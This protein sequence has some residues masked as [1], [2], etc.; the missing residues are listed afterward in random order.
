MT[1]LTCVHW[2]LGE[3]RVFT[4]AFHCTLFDTNFFVSCQ[5]AS[6]LSHHFLYH[7][8][9]SLSAFQLFLCPWDSIQ[10][11]VCW[12]L[13]HLSFIRAHS[14]ILP[15]PYFLPYSCLSWSSPKFIIAD[16]F[17]PEYSKNVCRHLFKNIC[18]LLGLEL[19][20]VLHPYKSTDFT[21]VSNFFLLICWHL[22]ECLSCAKALKL[23]NY[24]VLNKIS[25]ILSLSS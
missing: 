3:V 14:F 23:I 25:F 22:H 20:Q 13:S 11:L 17:W 24:M 15:F 9:P 7:P 10:E 4:K 21:M 16:S 18:D 19:F 5:V 8:P 6:P 12:C 2:F 1:Y